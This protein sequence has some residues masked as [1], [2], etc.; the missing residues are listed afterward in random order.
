MVK[1][2]LGKYSPRTTEHRETG[3]RQ[4]TRVQ[5]AG[6]AQEQVTAEKSECCSLKKA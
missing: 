1:S 4:Q 2:I 3:H 5:T 6:Q